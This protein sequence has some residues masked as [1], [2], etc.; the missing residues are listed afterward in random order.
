MIADLNKIIIQVIRRSKP[1]FLLKL[2]VVWQIGFRH[3]SEDFTFLYGNG[4]ID[5]L[6]VCP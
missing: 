1:T 2:F 4:R 6:V 3:N 5:Q